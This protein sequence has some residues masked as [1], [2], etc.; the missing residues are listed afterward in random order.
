M[1]I[2]SWAMLMKRTA[3][4]LVSLLA[5]SS[6]AGSA[7][8]ID[9]TQ[10][11]RLDGVICADPEMRDFQGRI[12]AAYSKAM[13]IWGGAIAPYVRRDQQEW[14]MAF[15][16]METVEA[17]I[18]EDCALSDADCIRAELRRRVEDME[19]AAYVHG[20]VYRAANGMKLL[21]LPG[22][23]ASYRVRLYDPAR[24][25]TVS[26]VTVEADRAAQWEGTQH[27]VSAMG[28]A[29]GLPLPAGDGC[30]VRLTPQPLSIQVTQTGLC[31]GHRYEG[32][33]GRLLDETLRSY[34]LELR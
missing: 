16:T 3:Y 9:C 32:S 19:G 10:G 22:A 26:I 24:L 29:N 2:N 27:M 13:E 11:A 7:Q 5:L 6:A 8:A 12:A 28:D 21:L 23:S 17:G 31:K 33:Y 25:S 15:R 20:G 34:E 4:L 18:D 14:L 30:T 1:D